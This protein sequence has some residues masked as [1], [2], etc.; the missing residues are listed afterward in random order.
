LCDNNY[1]LTSCVILNTPTRPPPP[2]QC[3][4]CHW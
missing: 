2:T 4:V 3:R 1:K